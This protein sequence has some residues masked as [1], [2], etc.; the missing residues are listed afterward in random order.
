MI[1]L[2]FFRCYDEDIICFVIFRTGLPS[3]TMD[4]GHVTLM[5]IC[6]SVFHLV[7]SSE[8]PQRL[9]Q[10]QVPKQPLYVNE[11]SSP[12]LELLNNVIALI[13]RLD[14]IHK[15]ATFNERD[16]PFREVTS[17]NLLNEDAATFKTSAEIN[18]T[19]P[20]EQNK[21]EA[22]I[23]EKRGRALRSEEMCRNICGFCRNVLSMRWAALC[24][25]H[26]IFGG[27]GYDAC[28]TVWSFREEIRKNKL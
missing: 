6:T 19:V 22:A 3:G 17:E 1:E 18:N 11:K 12:I 28:H 9:S 16:V 24:D 2:S 8:P 25:S 23:P 26:C 21:S 20:L 13:G 4:F 27:R 7:M 15:Q 10:I 5:L 14:T